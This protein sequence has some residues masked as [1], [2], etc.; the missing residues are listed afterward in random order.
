MRNILI[1]CSGGPAAVGVIKSLKD[2]DFKGKVVSI[3]ADPLAVGGLMSDESYVVPNSDSSEYWEVVLDIIKKENINLILP[4][5]DADIKHF[6]SHKILLEGMGVSVFM[7][8]YNTIA[9]CQNKK[10]FYD[11]CKDKFSLPLTSRNH[12]DFKYPFFAKPNKGSGSRGCMV[13][14]K[15]SDVNGLH[16]DYIFQ[17]YLGGKEYTVDVLCDM[18]GQVVSIVP[19][20]R[21][22]VKAGISVKGQIIRDG[23]IE[24]I[25]HRLA[26][27]LNLKGP[28]CIQLK[29]DENG[30]P[31]VIEVNPRLGGG[32]YFSTLAGVNFI[33]LILRL[34]NREFISMI[35]G[36]PDEI[37]VVRYYN[38]IVV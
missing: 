5:G 12:M 33:E 7:S 15:L 23:Q 14:N 18:I 9:I 25:C 32:T 4:T 17:E 26:L 19:R 28:V 20:I 10:L 24:K 16:D 34:E 27:H 3:D 37:T 1:S 22:Q 30:N 36:E 13:I 6:A 29:E 8:D 11:M 31:K 35:A 38:E 21:L 2:I